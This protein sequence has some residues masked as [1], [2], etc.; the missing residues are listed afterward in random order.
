[1]LARHISPLVALGFLLLLTACRSAE[2]ASAGNPDE[3]GK[4]MGE[5]QKK[6]FQQQYQKK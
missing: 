4:K 6:S 5:A 3:A 2:Q 1:M